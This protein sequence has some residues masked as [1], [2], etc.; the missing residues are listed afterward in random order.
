MYWRRVGTYE[1]WPFRSS[2]V[3]AGKYRKSFSD[4]VAVISD[5][6]SVLHPYTSWRGDGVQSGRRRR[7][8]TR[9]GS[10]EKENGN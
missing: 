6:V 7:A 10:A 9:R 8:G 4:R 1:E 5:R 3:E 2:G